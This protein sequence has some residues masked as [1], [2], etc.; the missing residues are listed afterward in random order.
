MQDILSFT[1]A[2]IAVFGF[3]HFTASFIHYAWK[4]SALIPNTP[5]PQP[6]PEPEITPEPELIPNPWELPLDEAPVTASAPVAPLAPTLYLLPPAKEQP[7]AGK[8]RRKAKATPAPAFPTT[9][10][11][12]R[13]LCTER[14]LKGAGRWT[15]AQCLAALGAV[16]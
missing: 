3:A 4:R 8:P 1:A 5:T 2:G 14:G 7:T 10:R 15:K 13:K 9:V 6:S 11:E 16:A 12:L